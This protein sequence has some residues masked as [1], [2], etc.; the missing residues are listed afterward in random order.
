MSSIKSYRDLLVWQKAVDL[1]EEIYRLT[2]KFPKDEIYGLTSQLRRSAVSVPS[3][4]SEGHER[5]SAKDFKRFLHIALG[6]LAEAHT[7]LIIASRLSY[8]EIGDLKKL[9]NEIIQIQKM[10]HAL[11]RNLPTNI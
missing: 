9:E 7:Q 2:T 11:I 10:T 5:R 8:I 3:N 1:V 4:I 6:S